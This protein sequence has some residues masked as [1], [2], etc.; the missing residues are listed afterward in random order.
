MAR[1]ARL[2]VDGRLDNVSRKNVRGDSDSPRR[3][4]G[5]LVRFLVISV[6]HVVE[7]YAV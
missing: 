3:N 6:W 4:F 2:E 1:G 7:L 5:E